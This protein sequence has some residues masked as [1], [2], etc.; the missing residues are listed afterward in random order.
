[1]KLQKQSY[2]TPR[3]E[4]VEIES[5]V[6]LCGSGMKGNSTESFSIGTFTM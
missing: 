3:V 1:M 6:V 5:Q 4:V 2:E